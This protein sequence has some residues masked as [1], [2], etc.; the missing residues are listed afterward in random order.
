MGEFYYGPE[1]GIRKI[2]ARFQFDPAE[3]E[4]NAPA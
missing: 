4:K 1:L 2:G 3:E